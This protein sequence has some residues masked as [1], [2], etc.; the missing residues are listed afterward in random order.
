MRFGIY[1]T[2][3]IAAVVGA[4]TSQPESTP[5]IYVSPSTFEHL[6][7]RQLGEEVKRITREEA[8]G[9][10]EGK[11][12]DATEIGLRKGAMEALEQ[13]SIEKGCNIQF[14]HG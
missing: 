11:A 13:V 7:C 10:Q 1:M 4:C 14:Q 6:T 12:A 2:L 9:G 5:P 3:G 8:A